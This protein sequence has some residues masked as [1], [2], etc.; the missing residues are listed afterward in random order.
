MT[1]IQ[2]KKDLFNGGKCFT[3]G[4]TYTVNADVKTEAGLMDART[5]NDLNESHIIGAYWRDFKIVK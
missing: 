3:K 5:V 1:T 4:R 2:A